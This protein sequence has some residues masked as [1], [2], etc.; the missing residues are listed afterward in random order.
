VCRI[1]KEDPETRFIRVIAMSGY[2]T[3]E[4]RN[5]VVRAGAE[6]CLTKPFTVEALKQTL[7]LFEP[8]SEREMMTE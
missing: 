5:D 3:S 8:E 2:C 7:G 4:N 6:T 1:I